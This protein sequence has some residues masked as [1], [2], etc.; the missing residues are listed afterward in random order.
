MSN[1]S[2][3]SPPP[4]AA[5]ITMYMSETIGKSLSAQKPTRR[6]LINIHTTNFPRNRNS[7][8]RKYQR[9]LVFQLNCGYFKS[10]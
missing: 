2:P 8:L 1:V 7:A 5:H 6:V 3:Q 10:N 4:S 9:D